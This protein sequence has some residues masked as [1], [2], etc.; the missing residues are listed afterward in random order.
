M[1]AFSLPSADNLLDQLS[2][3]SWMG[4]LDMGKQFLNFPL[5]PKLQEYCGIDLCPYCMLEDGQAWW[6]RWSQCMMDLCTSPY[7]TI[8]STL[9]EEKPW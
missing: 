8:Q 6:L 1:P 5:H 3:D 7:T 9:L 4:N 2:A